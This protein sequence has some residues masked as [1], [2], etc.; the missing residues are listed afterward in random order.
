MWAGARYDGV[1]GMWYGKGPGVDRSIDVIKH[2]N[3]AGTSPHGGVLALCGDDHSCKSSTMP[4]Q[5]DQA[6]ISA[7]VPVL[8]PSNVQDVLDM[9]LYGWALSRF[10]GL[11]VGFKLISDTV[12]TAASVY[13][14]PGRVTVK[15]PDNADD[16]GPYT[17]IRW[18]DV[19]LEQE[20]RLH[21]FKI[22]AAL[23]FA[24]VNPLNKTIVKPEKG[25]MKL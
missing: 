10:S 23:A 9:G 3:A 12:E 17:S 4:H 6:L 14:D 7:F 1:F 2:A 15:L 13:G 19:S 20:K 11:W 16:Y 24:R 5:S 25:Q 8:S 22:P 18:P 21:D